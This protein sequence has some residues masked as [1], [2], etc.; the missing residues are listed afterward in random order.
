MNKLIVNSFLGLG[1][2]SVAGMASAEVKTLTFTVENKTGHSYEVSLSSKLKAEDKNKAGC[3][4]KS[5]D[6][7]IICRTNNEGKFDTSVVA[8]FVFSTLGEGPTLVIN[9]E[10]FVVRNN[11]QGNENLAKIMAKMDTEGKW[12]NAE[13][14]VA[15]TFPK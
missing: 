3:T 6:Q 7:V 15:I 12:S 9:E 13:K 1:L 2:L 5:K 4:V 8:T 10:G 14:S 11:G